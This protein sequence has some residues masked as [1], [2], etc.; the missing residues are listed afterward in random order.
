MNEKELKFLRKIAEVALVQNVSVHH[1]WLAEG[2]LNL[3]QE[4]GELLREAASG[5][6][7][8]MI[9]RQVRE[10]VAAEIEAYRESER[11]RINEPDSHMITNYLGGMCIAARIA[12]KVD[13]DGPATS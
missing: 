12:R 7:G 5:C 2:V 3:L 10:Q 13:F 11:V 8:A 4:R 6:E 9:A 1:R